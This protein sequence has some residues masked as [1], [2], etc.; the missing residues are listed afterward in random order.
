MNIGNLNSKVSLYPNPVKTHLNINWSNFERA[1]I[2]ELS[3]K[4]LFE[5]NTRT[6]DLQNLNAG[7]Y[8]I[9][10]SGTESE[11]ITYRIIKE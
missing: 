10:L 6:I 9:T 7:V 2:S 4:Q 1:V 8:L 11:R 3:G 5:A